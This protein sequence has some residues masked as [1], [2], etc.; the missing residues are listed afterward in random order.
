MTSIIE[1]RLSLH[2]RLAEQ[3]QENRALKSQNTQLQA[4]ATLGSATCMIAHE[5]N[6]LLTPLTT[7][8]AL[9]V[10]NPDDAALAKKVLDKTVRNC[11]RASRIMQSMLAM[12]NGQ[13]RQ[14]ESAR[15]RAMVDEVFTCLCRDFAKDSIVVQTSIPEDLQVDCVPI[16]MEQVL[17]NLVLNARDAMLPGGG[18]LKIVAGEDG[19]QV[20]ITVSDTGRGIP[21][22]HLPDIFRPFFTTKTQKDRPAGSN[23]GSGVGLAFCRRIV[24][25]HQGQID[26]ASQPGKGSSF[27][28]RLPRKPSHD[29]L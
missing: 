25:A 14:Q 24:D 2:Q 3:E 28:I 19:D 21:P 26:V 13:D 4:L 6:N 16:Q 10:Q 7:Y 15:V 1:K 27:T 17:M 11:K 22:E 8:A 5:I 12:A 20:S 18:I 9:A 23:S 29:R